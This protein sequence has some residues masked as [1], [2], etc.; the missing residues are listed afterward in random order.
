LM[1]LAVM[2]VVFSVWVVAVTNFPL[3]IGFVGLQSLTGIV[4]MWTMQQYR[5]I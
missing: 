4:L 1:W 2:W 5:N 3:N